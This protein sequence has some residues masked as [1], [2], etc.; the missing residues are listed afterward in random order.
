M[1]TY[2]IGDVQGCYDTLQALLDIIQ[3][4]PA[5]DCLG[6]VGD[7]V[8]RGP[9]SLETLRFIKSLPHSIVVLGNHDLYLL[10]TAYYFKSIPNNISDTLSEILAAPDY[11]E[12]VQWLLQKPLMHF[13]REQ[14][15]AMVH[16][17][18]PP[19]WTIEQA[20]QLA[21]SATQLMR[22][23]PFEFFQNLYGNEPALFHDYLSKW[24]R[25]RYII[26]ALTRMRFCNQQGRLE[27]NRKLDFSIDPEFRPWFNWVNH[28]IDLFF[29]HWS[30]LDPTQCKNPK[31][32][33]LDTGCVWA[34]ELTA[35]RTED[36]KVFS[37]HAAE[38]IYA[39]L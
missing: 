39:G 9:K 29:G 1:K 7:L 11:G 25:A 13:D 28:D 27:L 32:H 24:D 23:D 31:V 33:P 20:F 21:E 34:G 6:F 17:G 30:S 19:M 10:S 15:F 16:A 8:N 38:D 12:L 3:F 18:I 5:E 37:V 26:N 36:K 35:K 14:K 4:D 2:I 22:T